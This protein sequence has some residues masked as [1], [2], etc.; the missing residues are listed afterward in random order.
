MGGR[1][2]KATKRHFRTMTFLRKYVLHVFYFGSALHGYYTT[3]IRSLYRL[4]YSNH[5]HKNITHFQRNIEESHQLIRIDIF[6][7]VSDVNFNVLEFL[8]KTRSEEKKKHATFYSPYQ[9]SKSSIRYTHML[10]ATFDHYRWSHLLIR[11]AQSSR[12]W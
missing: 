11:S 5:K 3:R 2:Q 1:E 12:I 6:I 7:C 10:Q 9:Q 4:H 8:F